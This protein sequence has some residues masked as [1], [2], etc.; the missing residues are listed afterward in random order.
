MIRTIL[1]SLAAACLVIPAAGQDELA[2]RASWSVPTAETVKG[3]VFDWIATQKLDELRTLE[4]EAL[5]PEG[6][7]PKPGREVLE[8]V[9]VTIGAVDPDAKSI[10]ELCRGGAPNLLPAEPALLAA[11]DKAP[12]VLHNMRLYY[13]CWL[14]QSSFYD[15]ANQYLE[16]LEPG[17]VVDP[18]SLLFYQSVVAHR[19]LKKEDCLASL[20]KLLENEAVLPRRYLS[21][22]KLMQ[23]DI[24]PLKVDSLDE[25]SRL[26]DDIRRRLG[27]GRAGTK[28]RD[29]E[30]DVIAKLDKM[31]EDLEKQRKQ[32]QQASGANANNLQPSKPAEDSV[33]AGGSG[34]GDIDPRRL[35]NKGA[36]GNLPPKDRQEALQQISK[37]LPA[38]FREVIEEYFRKL[39]KDGDK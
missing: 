30:D 20:E 5:W 38:H 4:V 14:A 9:A 11:A 18:G 28:V 34:P 29:Q 33:P 39:A 31:I 2:K 27:F 32:Q 21:V 6:S 15:E 16:G 35:A 13:A 22:A 7:L 37:D 25:V 17:Q 19:L 24:A 26:M 3:Q 8:Q 1:L 12:F 23:A 10:V 36:W